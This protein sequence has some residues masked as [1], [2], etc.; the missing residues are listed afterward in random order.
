MASLLGRIPVS[1]VVAEFV[2]VFLFQFIGGGADAN[3]ISTGLATAAIGNGLAFIVLVYATSGTS[4]GHLNPAIS[5]AFV[6]T[7]RLGRR[8]YFIYIAAQVLGAIFG[9]LALKL[10]L[11]PAMDETPFIT[12]GS[13]TFTH[14]FQVFFLEFLCTF[15]LVFSVFA[16]AVDKAGV[17]KNASPIAIGLAIIVGTFA[18]GPFTGGSMNPARTLGPA[19]AFGMFRHVWVYVLATMAGGACAG[20]LYDKVFLSES[21]DVGDIFKDG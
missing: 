10:A 11:P 14:P 20:L 16:T 2:G 7:G 9:A 12:T 4:G 17:A 3:S 1:C 18:E 5:T 21:Q 6:V 8:R 13:L 15:T 19:F